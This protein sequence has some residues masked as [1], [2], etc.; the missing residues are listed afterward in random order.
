MRLLKDGTWVKSV[1][2]VRKCYSAATLF[3]NVAI[4]Q[5]REF[6]VSEYNKLRHLH[7]LE[8]TRKQHY[9]NVD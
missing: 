7:E 3:F 6:L 4:S 8:K 5:S 2:L 9:Y 1:N